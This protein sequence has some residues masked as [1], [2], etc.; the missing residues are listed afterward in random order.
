MITR[1]ALMLSIAVT[2][3]A[4][5]ATTA[6]SQTS[7]A[8]SPTRTPRAKFLA[9][10][11]ERFVVTPTDSEFCRAL[12]GRRCPPVLIYGGAAGGALPTIEPAFKL[13]LPNVRVSFVLQAIANEIVANGGVDGDPSTFV[14]W[15]TTSSAASVEHGGPYG[16][17]LPPPGVTWDGDDLYHTTRIC[18]VIRPVYTRAFGSSDRAQQSTVAIDSRRSC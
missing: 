7:Q 14:Q 1:H 6:S 5:L 18:A 12:Q 10:L 16:Y 17:V 4:I 13:H 15:L 9:P 8:A 11:P 2:L 3:T